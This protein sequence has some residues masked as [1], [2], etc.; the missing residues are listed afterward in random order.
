MVN[1]LTY[2]RQLTR[3]YYKHVF[4]VFILQWT[5]NYFKKKRTTK[6]NDNYA[7]PR[8]FIAMVRAVETMLD[9]MRI[10]CDLF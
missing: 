4:S 7:R 3:T 10:T 8:A 9:V 2:G 5:R 6:N 1:T